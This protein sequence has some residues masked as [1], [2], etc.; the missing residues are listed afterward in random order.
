MVQAVVRGQ[1]W[2]IAPTQDTIQA[3]E[4][5]QQG[6]MGQEEERQQEERPRREEA[7]QGPTPA[8]VRLQGIP[9]L[10]S[11]EEQAVQ[12]VHHQLS[13]QAYLHLEDSL[14]HGLHWTDLGKLYRSSPC[15]LTTRVGLTGL[16]SLCVRIETQE[17]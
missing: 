11:Q 8:A 15:P 7:V 17:A 3:Q 6:P 4:E 13:L 10:S 5:E 2:V 16:K 12:A 9:P 1:E 14:I